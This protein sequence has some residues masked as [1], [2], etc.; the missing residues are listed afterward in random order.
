M[1]PMARPITAGLRERL[2]LQRGASA[3]TRECSASTFQLL[4]TYVSQRLHLR[5]SDLCLEHIDAP[6]V[7]DCRA[8]LEAERGNT[9]R[10]GT[11]RFAAIASCMRFGEYRGPASLGQS[12]RGLAIPTKK[13]APPLVKHLS[14]A[15]MYAILDAPEVQTRSGLRERAMLHLGFAA[16]LRV[17]ALLTLPLTAL[18]CYPTPTIR[19][20]GKGAETA[21]YLW[22]NNRPTIGGR[23]WLSGVLS[24]CLKWSCMPRAE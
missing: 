18:T 20:L 6:I 3:H 7:L 8:H 19:G 24:A 13:T 11:T 4:L 1:P 12:R 14:M 2:P 9:P 16:G 10:P 23:G 17:S 15:E 5:P 21:P 22:G